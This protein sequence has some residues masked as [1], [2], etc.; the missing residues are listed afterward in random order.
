VS[1]EPVA[2]ESGAGDRSSARTGA[3]DLGVEAAGGGASYDGGRL[4]WQADPASAPTPL[5]TLTA[6]SLGLDWTNP[7]ARN[8]DIS[9]LQTHALVM[10]KSLLAS[11][12]ELR[13]D[14]AGHEVEIGA[15]RRA[16]IEAVSIAFSAGFIAAALRSSSLW[17]A[18]LSLTPMWQRLDPLVV[19]AVSDEERRRRQEEIRRA[20]ELRSK[21]GRV[22]DEPARVDR[23]RSEGQPE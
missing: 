21:V 19:L 3:V 1:V 22:L 12:E 23:R 8:R 6:A 4:A 11:I 7:R 18:L 5:R 15:W 13:Q 2:I 9:E 20:E 14:L 17:A 10:S 16:S